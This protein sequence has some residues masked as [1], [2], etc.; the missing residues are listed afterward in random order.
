M[1]NITDIIDK[2]ILD[3]STMNIIFVHIQ[4]M[5]IWKELNQEEKKEKLIEIHDF[6]KPNITIPIWLKDIIE[7]KYVKFPELIL[8][9]RITN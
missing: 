2:K 7:K 1:K 5:E 3:E 6:Y 4:G 9:P 8:P